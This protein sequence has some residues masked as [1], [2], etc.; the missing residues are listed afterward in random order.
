MA[1]TAAAPSPFISST[2]AAAL[3]A[4][5]MGPATGFTL[6]QLMEMAGL[7]CAA[8]LPA[9]GLPPSPS[10]RVLV[11]AGPGNNGGDGLVAARHLKLWGYDVDVCYPKRPASQPHY[12]RLVAQLDAVGVP[13]LD[14]AAV[15]VDGGAR[16]K[17]GTWAVV[18]DALLGFGARGAPRPPLD[19]LIAALSPSAGP[20]PILAVDIPSGWDVDGG[21]TTGHGARPAI[22]VSLTAPKPCA[23]TFTGQHHFIGGR[24]MPP[25]LADRYGLVLPPYPADGSQVVRV[26]GTGGAILGASAPLPP[27]SS[28]AAMRA[29]YGHPEASPAVPGSDLPDPADSPGPLPVFEAWFGVATAARVA[30]E[31]N[32]MCLSTVDPDT[33]APSSRYVLMK[34][35]GERGIEF[36]TNLN[37][38]KGRELSAAAAASAGRSTPRASLVFYWEPMRRSVRVEGT[39]IAVPDEEADAYFASRPRGSRVGAHAS[40]QSQPLLGGRAELEAAVAEAEAAFGKDEASPVPRPAG[41]GGFIV[42]PTRWE[43]WTGRS[44]RLHDRVVFDKRDGGWTVSRLAP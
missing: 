3:D 21:D 33:G 41:W 44:S 30:E 43:F 17:P 4:E 24:F 19:K 38:R 5:L 16:L 36:Y 25:A 1:T 26:G 37:S 42:Q 12:A 27:P 13:L 8:A 2:D 22:L 31:P 9:A 10:T 18:V 39:V 11:L 20:P 6:E 23:A 28:V 29:D 14:E 32:A 40:R 15:L 34:G 35:Y 7:A